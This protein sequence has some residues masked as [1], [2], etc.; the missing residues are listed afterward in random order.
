[1]PR[2]Q[3]PSDALFARAAELRAAG[4]SWE[5]IAKEVHRRERTVRGWPRKYTD[6]WTTALIQAEQRMTAQ[7]DCES[8]FTLRKLLLSQDEK[9]RWHAAKA[10]IGRRVDHKKIE[11]KSPPPPNPALSNE[12]AR[13]IAFLDGQPD[14]ELTAIAAELAPL[15]PAAINGSGPLP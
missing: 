9:V 10:L 2:Q 6:R 8:V 14:E 5:A 11:L 1:M 4:A 7:A 15:P 13:I 12:A 3:P